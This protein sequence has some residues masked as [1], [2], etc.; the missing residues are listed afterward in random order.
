M[1][2]SWERVGADRARFEV[3]V[4]AERVSRA[5]ERA[6][7]KVVQKVNVPGFRRGKAPRPILERFVGKGALAEEALDEVLPEAYGE[8]VRQSGLD[9]IDRPQL[10]VEKMEDGEPLVFKAEVP[11]KPEVQLGTYRDLE[12]EREVPEVSEADVA[13]QLDLL[14][15]RQT[16]LVTHDGPAETGHYAV[17]DFTGYADG[18]PFEGGQASDYVLPLGSGTFIPG[19]EDQLFGARAGEEREVRVAFP[20]DYNAAHLA[21]KDAT[22]EVKVNEVKRREK[23]AIDDELA[24]GLGRFQSLQEL[25]ADLTNRLQQAADEAATRLYEGRIVEKVAAASEVEPPEVLVH[26]RVHS[27]MDDLFDRVRSQGVDPAQ[28]LQSAGKTTDDLHREFHDPAKKA[29]KVDLVLEA[30]ARRE[31][32]T[33]GDDEVRA[34]IERSVRPYD[35]QAE[36]MRRLLL[37]PD[38]FAAIREALLRDKARKHLGTLQKPVDKAVSAREVLEPKPAPAT[39]NDDT[40]SVSSV[41]EEGQASAGN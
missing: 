33:V 14:A 27:M 29:V 12:V 19:F 15:E 25:Q 8:A 22:F 10:D 31:G 41:S 11:V 36:A 26:R 34:E 30:I 3:E 38:R 1:K 28:F 6:Y 7:R 17:I 21:G 39:K 20:A 23:P 4:P 37:S 35:E 13:A 2:A 18:Q 40:A 16:Q 5:F 32:L 9:P 24:R